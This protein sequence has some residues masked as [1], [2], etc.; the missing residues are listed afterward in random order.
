M[1]RQ[2]ALIISDLKGILLKLA[3]N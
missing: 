2:K 1:A 3:D